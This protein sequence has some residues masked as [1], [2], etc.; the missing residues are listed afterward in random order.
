MGQLEVSHDV[1]DGTFSVWF[2]FSS[3][4]THLAVAFVVV[5]YLSVVSKHGHELDLVVVGPLHLRIGADKGV[6]VVEP[7]DKVTFDNTCSK[8]QG[9]FEAARPSSSPL[10]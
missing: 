7:A 2:A 4:S 6:V 8:R 3:E 9:Q 1:V 5:E 10:N